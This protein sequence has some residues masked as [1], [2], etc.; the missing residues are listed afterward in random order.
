MT[1]KCI[2]C[3]KKIEPRNKY[4]LKFDTKKYKDTKHEGKV[5]ACSDNCYEEARAYLGFYGRYKTAFGLLCAL[6]LIAVLVFGLFLKDSLLCAVGMF[7]MAATVIILPLG[8][9]NSIEL[10]SIKKM[11]LMARFGGL[12]FAG[13]GNWT[14]LSGK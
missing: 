13:F 4:T 9:P 8:T 3:G 2:Y 1:H 7:V 12:I 14:I 10:Y 6:A 5:Y 11:K